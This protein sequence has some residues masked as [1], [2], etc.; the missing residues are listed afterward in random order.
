MSPRATIDGRSGEFTPGETILTLARRLGIEIPTLCYDDAFPPEGNCR[1]CMIDGGPKHGLAAACHTPLSDGAEIH[2]STPRLE[3]IREGVLGLLLTKVEPTRFSPSPAGNELERMLARVN[4]AMELSH[5]PAPAPVDDSHPYLRFDASRCIVC[6]RCVHA[7]ERIQGQFVYSV[8]GRGGAAHIVYGPSEQFSESDCVACGACV[9]HC[10]TGAISD[11]DRDAEQRTSES[12]VRSTC[13][14]CGVGCQVDVHI[15]EGRVHSID[16]PREAAVNRGHLCAKGR[17][18]HAYQASPDRLTRPLLRRDGKLEPVAWETAIGWIAARMQDLKSRY[19]PDSLGALASSRSTNEAAYLLQKFMRAVVG[20]NNVDCCARVCH[21]STALALLTVTGTSGASASFDDIERA[22][23]IV[24]AGANP[25]EA[26]PVVGARIKQAALR[27]TPVIVIDPRRIEL[28]AYARVHLAPNPGTNVPLFNAIARAL[29]EQGAVD[30]AYVS[31]RTEGFEAFRAHVA[32]NDFAETCRVCGVAEEAVRRAAGIIAAAGPT[33]FVSGLGLSELTQGT[34][35]VIALCNIGML[36]G[37]IGRPG[38]GMLPLRGQNNVQGAADMGAAPAT[39]TG[40]HR[41][42]DPRVRAHFEALWESPLPN[43]KGL[44]TREMM[45]AAVEGRLRGLWVQGEDLVHSDPHESHT[46]R[47]LENL[48]LLIV[49]DPFM[50]ETAPFAHVVLPATTTLE[51]E[52]TYTNGERRVQR[53]RPALPCPGDARMD[54][55]ITADVANAM[56][57]NWNYASPADVMGEI[58]AAAPSLF[59]G[60]SYDRLDGDGLQWPCPTRDHPGSRTVHETGFAKGK[61]TFTCVA[62]IPSPEAVTPEFPLALITG[63]VLQ[64]YNVGTMTRRTPNR[65]LTGRDVIEVNPADAAALSLH[66]GGLVRVTSQWG[67]TKVY[68]RTSE[69]VRPGSAFLSFHY[70]DS[71]TNRLVGPHVDPKSKCPE[72][73][74]TAVRIEPAGVTAAP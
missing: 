74:L 34:D 19:G 53:V 48:D 43:V 1:L 27:G 45:D 66:D 31:E 22:R 29:I 58:A 61:G 6:R 20:T 32:S 63:R 71:H 68:L 4:P 13:G 39:A 62:H 16:A 59:G 37:S 51:N 41:V 11:R 14:Y 15:S 3:R 5:C 50:N 30:E 49:Q 28:S 23:C 72:Y 10:P 17:Y 46:I 47:A 70:A 40:Y 56:G 21:S 44:T 54:W 69:R 55:R 25:T 60:I 36:T 42:D 7:C 18:A 65:E 67:E 38:A 33:L 2:T 24:V 8:A 57:A 9:D 26:H 52:G 35:S 12:Q 73:K 64:H